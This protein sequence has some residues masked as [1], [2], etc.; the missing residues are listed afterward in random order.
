MAI[1]Y[2]IVCTSGDYG[3]ALIHYEKGITSDPKVLLMT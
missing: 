2:A 1:D 3:N